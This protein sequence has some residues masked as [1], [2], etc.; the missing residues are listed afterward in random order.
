MYT[1]HVFHGIRCNR[2]G[3]L[4]EN[5]ED[6]SFFHDKGDVMESAYDD[7]WEEVKGSHYCPDCYTK[8]EDDN[9]VPKPEYP[10][11]VGFVKMFV[12]TIQKSH[13]N[14]TEHTGHF[15]VKYYEIYGETKQCDIAWLKER[16]GDSLRSFERNATPRASSK[17]VVIILEKQDQCKYSTLSAS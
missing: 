5:S 6:A 7:G 3:D 15:E 9:V 11:S 17:E 13:P 1:T 14:V 16:L 2:C 4:Y 10:K 8:D 12:K